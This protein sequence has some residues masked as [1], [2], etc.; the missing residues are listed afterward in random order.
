MV[1]NDWYHLVIIFSPNAI[2][3]YVNGE[4]D[5]SSEITYSAYINS[6]SLRIG[7]DSDGGW[8]YFSGSI[9]DIRIYD[10]VL[11]DEEIQELYHENG[12][13]DFNL[14]L[15]TPNSI[16][17][18]NNYFYDDILLEE[19]RIILAPYIYLQ[20][21]I[22]NTYY[23]IKVAAY[24]NDVPIN[25]QL[26][27]MARTLDDNNDGLID[28][29]LN[30]ETNDFAARFLVY[31]DVID[32]NISN[33]VIKIAI[34][35]INGNP[36]NI[37]WEKSLSYY[38]TKTN[39]YPS[40]LRTRDSYQFENLSKLT[41]QEFISLLFQ[42]GD[43]SINL[44][45]TLFAEITTWGG[46][47]WGMSATS[48]M[49][50][51][52]PETKPYTTDVY[53]WD[54]TDISVT[55]PI[56]VS[57]LN[58]I[59]Y[60]FNKVFPPTNHEAYEILKGFLNEYKPALL[61][62]GEIGES[63]GHAVLATAIVEINNNSFI[64]VY[65]NNY[66]YLS[67][68]AGLIYYNYDISSNQ[69]GTSELYSYNRFDAFSDLVFQLNTNIL[70]W[71]YIIDK[72]I[73]LLN[74]A[75]LKQISV[76][77][78]INLLITNSLNQKYGFDADGNFINEISGCSHIKVPTSEGARDSVTI[79]Y[80]PHEENYQVTMFS[81]DEGEMLFSYNKSEIQNQLISLYKDSLTITTTTIGH[82]DELNSNHQLT[83]DFDGD[84]Q[85]DTTINLIQTITSIDNRQDKLPTTFILSQNYPNPF[86]P[87]T[88]INFSIPERSDV[89]LKVYDVLGKEVATLVNEEKEPGYYTVD[90]N[91]NN[92]AS[93]MYIYRITA[94]SFVE[95]RKMILM[96]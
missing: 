19:D 79:I 60:I 93:G 15:Y 28:S 42:I 33:G 55:N 64:R 31:T 20:N 59:I 12:W 65:D 51:L 52:Y 94:G 70:S 75:G 71:D 40:F 17:L 72:L 38:Y 50:F 29:I 22:A 78:P 8:E 10:R 83:L 5:N 44:F 69:F 32:N 4:Y 1:L 25:I 49:Y 39:Q 26:N 90:F 66:P 48:G 53:D 88:Q 43:P 95:T 41:W 86:N 76:G 30:Y 92:L 85:P 87:I 68:G 74:I 34:E 84:G 35:E 73:G 11:S 80:A 27:T 14:I 58:Q 57:H 37:F 7:V 96:K 91:G 18:T 13:T 62:L 82:F 24:L 61:S 45:T 23:N 54:D 3:Y 46:R 21:L 9:D 81:Y 47:C 6:D 63:G 77:C 36:V 16:D 67:G 2:T 56:T 89:T